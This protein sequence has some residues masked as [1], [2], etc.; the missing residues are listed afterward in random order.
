[1]T[2]QQH[3]PKPK[4]AS[5]PPVGRV[6]EEA[7]KLKQGAKELVKPGKLLIDG[8]WVPAASGKTFATYNPATKEKLTEIAAGDAEDVDRAVKASSRAR[9]LVVACGG[10]DSQA[11]PTILPSSKPWTTGRLFPIRGQRMPSSA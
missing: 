9:P 10:A 7:E 6:E 1:M 3:K 8:K 11:Q 2:G 5:A 4:P